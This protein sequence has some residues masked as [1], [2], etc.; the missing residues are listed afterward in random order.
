MLD[1]RDLMCRNVN[2]T[3]ERFKTNTEILIYATFLYRAYLER[4]EIP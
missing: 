4:G 3:H 2:H 1:G